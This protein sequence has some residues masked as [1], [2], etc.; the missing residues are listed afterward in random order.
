MDIVIEK[1]RDDTPEG[2]TTGFRLTLCC[3]SPNGSTFELDVPIMVSGDV[4]ARNIPLPKLAIQHLERNGLD[5]WPNLF[6]DS[7]HLDLDKMTSDGPAYP[8]TITLGGPDVV[9]ERMV[10]HIERKA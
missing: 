3:R 2:L 8:L 10:E 1:V 7:R 6:V 5:Q 9:N 4:V